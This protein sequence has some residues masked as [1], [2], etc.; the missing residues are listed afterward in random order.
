MSNITLE[1]SKKQ[2]QKKIGMQAVK[3]SLQIQEGIFPQRNRWKDSQKREEG[4]L[5]IMKMCNP[6]W[7][8]FLNQQYFYFQRERERERECICVC[9]CVCVCV[10]GVVGHII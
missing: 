7:Y 4:L 9:V 8:V 1:P 5:F 3:E 6:I 10:W 2:K